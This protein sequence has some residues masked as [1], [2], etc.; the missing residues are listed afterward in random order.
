MRV[1]IEYYGLFRDYSKK[2]NEEIEIASSIK[3]KELFKILA[4]KYGKIFE[5]IIKNKHEAIILLNGKSINLLDGLETV[6][7]NDSTLTIL[8]VIGGGQY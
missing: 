7:N 3:I 1:A 6:I 5:D 2:K 4:E 8:P